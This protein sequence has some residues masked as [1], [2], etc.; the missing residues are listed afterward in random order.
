[1]KAAFAATM[2]AAEA[3][4]GKPKTI[5]DLAGTSNERVSFASL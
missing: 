5:A 2:A 1:M 4:Y 3:K